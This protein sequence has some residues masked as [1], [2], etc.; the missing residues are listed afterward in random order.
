MTHDDI[1][2]HAAALLRQYGDAA[3]LQAAMQACEA[4]ERLDLDQHRIWLSVLRTIAVI[5]RIYAQQMV[6]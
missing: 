1:R 4:L 3:G 6:Q 5:D 2:E